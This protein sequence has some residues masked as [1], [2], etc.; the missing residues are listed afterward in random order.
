MQRHTILGERAGQEDRWLIRVGVI[1]I[2][3]AQ[4]MRSLVANVGYFH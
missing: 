4:R 3:I 1:A 2:A